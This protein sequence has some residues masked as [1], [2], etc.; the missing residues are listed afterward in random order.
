M[1]K[2]GVLNGP[3]L[4]LLGQRNKDVYG[5]CT[6]QDIENALKQEAEKLGCEL[7]FHQSN[8]EGDLIETL[9]AWREEGLS[10][11]IINAGGYS[12]TS[13]ALRDAIELL[14]VRTI[15][16][17]ISNIYGREDFRR[18]SIT[19]SAAEGSI[20]G[21]GMQGYVMALIYLDGKH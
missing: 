21:L 7:I 15:E 2:Y 13:V 10:G 5:T 19:A 11:L 9:H 20:A 3:N 1:K 18:T 4:N 16:V 6:L 14:G 8:H 17:H 12:H